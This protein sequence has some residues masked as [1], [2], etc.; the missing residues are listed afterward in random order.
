MGG[1]AG[2]RHDHARAAPQLQRASRGW[3][4]RCSKDGT[5]W[6]DARRPGHRA[7]ARQQ[8]DDL[9]RLPHVVDP[10][11]F[12]CHLPL[13]ANQQDAACCTTRATTSRN[14]TSYNFQTLRDDVF[15]LGR[16]GTVTGNRIVAGALG[17]RG[18]RQLAEPEPRVDLLAAADGL[19]RGASA[20]TAFSTYVPH[21]VRGQGDQAAAPTATSRKA[22][23]NNAWMAQL[24]MQGTNYMNFIGRYAWVAD[25][26]HGLRGGRRH[27]AR[28]AARRSSAATCTSSPIPTSY[29]KHRDG[30]GC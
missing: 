30:G 16:D 6:G 17:L 10:S 13:K 12:G 20:G 15:M 23:D 25:G 2:R 9:L 27:R 29:E 28:R 3:P 24:L 19:G 8:Q 11:C 26:R 21:T 4:R 18:A 1:R 22:D 14:W 7:G 5:T